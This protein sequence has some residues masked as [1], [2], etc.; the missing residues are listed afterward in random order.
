MTK[1]LYHTA[2]IRTLLTQGFSVEELRILCYDVPDFRP[3]YEDLAP[4]S[5][6]TEIVTKLIEHADRRCIM[7]TLLALAKD[8]NP[9]QYEAREPY[10]TADATSALQEQVSGLAKRLA[11]LTSPSSLTKEMQYQIAS[12]W[13]DLGRK[14]SLRKFDL[15]GTDLDAI[16][17]SKADLRKANLTGVSL[18]LA[19]L[20]ETDLRLADLTEANLTEANLSGADLTWADLRA[21]GLFEANLSGANLSGADL[22]WTHLTEANLSGANLRKANLS[23]ANLRK[24]NLSGA[25]LSEANLSGANLSGADLSEANLTWADLSEANL[26]R[27]NLSRA[28]L[29]GANLRGANLSGAF[30]DAKTRWPTTVYDAKIGFAKFDPDAHGAVKYVDYKESID[31]V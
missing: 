9:A 19:N 17:L 10:Y 6:Q 8:R 21:A 5:P 3:V 14:D 11:A 29:G 7:E 2:N 25:N 23:G 4:N 31:A 12:N 1:Q 18:K 13:I 30:Y 16:D 15:S 20:S 26:N 22:T 24:A 28:G 27:A